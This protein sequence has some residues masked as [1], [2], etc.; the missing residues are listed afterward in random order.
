MGDF[1]Y[2]IGLGSERVKQLIKMGDLE[3]LYENDQV[4]EI[5]L[6]GMVTGS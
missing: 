3:T 1:N 5:Y 4:C 2:R 6:Y